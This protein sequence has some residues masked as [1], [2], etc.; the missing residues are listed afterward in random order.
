MQNTEAI[1]V[2]VNNPN[3]ANSVFDPIFTPVSL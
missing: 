1:F 3:V 2:F